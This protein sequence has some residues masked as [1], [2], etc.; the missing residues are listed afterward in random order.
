M[1]VLKIAA[2]VLVLALHFTASSWAAEIQASK[3]IAIPGGEGG[4]G[5][6]DMG[7]SQALGKV[8]VPAGR[9]GTIAL[10]EPGADAIQLISGF[11]SGEKFGG[12]RGESVTSA[13][14]GAGFMLATDRSAQVIDVV[15]VATRKI[16]GSAPLAAEPDYVRYVAATSEAWVTEPEKAR[17]EIFALKGNT[18]PKPTHAAFVEVPGGPEALVID[19]E[20]GRAYANRWTDSTVAIDLRT[21]A[22]IAQW[23][24]GCA[25]SR[26][27]AMDA[28]RSMLLVGCKEGKLAV[29][30]LKTGKRLGIASSGSGVDIIAYDARLRH[31]YLP[32]AASATM[33]VIGIEGSGAATVLGT[34]ATAKGAHCAAAD[35]SGN[36]YVC[37]PV[38]GR[39]LA[40]KDSFA[41]TK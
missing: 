21:R 2:I 16:V 4:I 32:G 11:S 5:F 7:Y 1:R 20:S 8:I 3:T 41:P 37:D 27:L 31:A 26:G 15:D 28:A 18:S 10:I 30:D 17:I 14:V 12:G 34:V 35:E 6:D 36:V 29:L 38:K 23:P 22:I 19:N 24:N 9:T 33:A 25:G 39:I 40:F 13:D